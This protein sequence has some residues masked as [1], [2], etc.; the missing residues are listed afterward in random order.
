MGGCQLWLAAIASFAHCFPGAVHCSQ[1]LVAQFGTNWVAV[2]E[3][4]D[5]RYDRHQVGCLCITLA[6]PGSA[7]ALRHGLTN[8]RGWRGSPHVRIARADYAVPDGLVCPVLGGCV[9]DALSSPA[10]GGRTHDYIRHW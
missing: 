4:F 2:S 5:G 7:A 1:A 9:S 8:S 6:L 3:A 10:T